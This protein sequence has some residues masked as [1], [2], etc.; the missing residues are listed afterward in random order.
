MA[1]HS[2][3]PTNE[4]HLKCSHKGVKTARD[5]DTC[6]MYISY[7]YLHWNTVSLMLP[8]QCAVPENTDYERRALQQCTYD[9]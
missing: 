7:R 4:T 6:P 2:D 9:N 3:W 1:Q 5:V 8:E